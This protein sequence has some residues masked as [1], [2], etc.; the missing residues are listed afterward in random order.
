M[1]SVNPD[2]LR[3]PSVSRN[4]PGSNFLGMEWHS[5]KDILQAGYPGAELTDG[6]QPVGTVLFCLPITQGP[7]SLPLQPWASSARMSTWR[8]R[9]SRG[10]SRES[11]SAAPPTMSQR[12][13]SSESKSP[14]TVSPGAIGGQGWGWSWRGSP[15]C[16]TR[17]W[18]LEVTHTKAPERDRRQQFF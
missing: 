1:H 12:P 17:E 4:L 11:T 2:L 14:S 15:C 5:H 18:H 16:P 7:L 6:D 13:S 9:G 10:S 8:S 3:Q